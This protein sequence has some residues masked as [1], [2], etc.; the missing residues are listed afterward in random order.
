M[1]PSPFDSRHAIWC[2]LSTFISGRSVSHTA[3]YSQVIGFV[4]GTGPATGLSSICNGLSWPPEGALL[5]AAAQEFCKLQ[6]ENQTSVFSPYLED[7][8]SSWH[9]VV[10]TIDG[11]DNRGKGIDHR[12]INVVQLEREGERLALEFLVVFGDWK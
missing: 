12:T 1:F 8:G 3:L 6:F 5:P 2:G 10:D 9:W 4:V 11:E 7:V